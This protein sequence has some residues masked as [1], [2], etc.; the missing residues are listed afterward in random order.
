M[1]SQLITLS[2]PGRAPAQKPGKSAR[3]RRKRTAVFLPTPGSPG[4][5][6]THAQAPAQTGVRGMAQGN[7][8]AVSQVTF[9]QVPVRSPV[10]LRGKEGTAWQTKP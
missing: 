9:F 7:I 2:A 3:K 1:S 5:V 4:N 10:M 8:P 6:S